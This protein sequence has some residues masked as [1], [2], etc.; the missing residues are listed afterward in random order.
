MVLLKV[1]PKV[2]NNLTLRLPAL[3]PCI[4]FYGGKKY[5]YNLGKNRFSTCSRKYAS[6]ARELALGNLNMKWIFPFPTLPSED[7]LSELNQLSDAVG[8]FFDEKVDSK[9]MDEEGKF[10]P[11]VVQ[12]LKDLGLFGMQIPV[13][14]GGLGL[15][16]VQYARVA[17]ELSSDAAVTVMLAA[18]QAI[19]LKGILIAGSEEQKMEYL[20]KLA[21]G[22][23]AA[24]FCLTEPSSG[25]DAASIQSKAHLSDDGQ[26]WVLNGEK[27]WITNGGFADVMT[28]FAKTKVMDV[29]D[30]VKEKVTAFIVERKFGG[31]SSGKPEDKL[32]IRASNTCA[33]SFVDTHIPVKNVL[34]EVGGGF[35]IAMNILNSGRFSMGTT[36]AGQLKRLITLASEYANQRTQFGKKLAEFELI[37]EKIFNMAMQAY[38]MESMAYMTAGQMDIMDS[39]GE[40]QDC[41]IEAAMVKIYSSECAWSSVSECLQIFGG[42]GYMKDFPYER[43]LRDSRILLIFEGTNEILRLYVALASLQYAGAKLQQRL[44]AF[45]AG[46]MREKLTA[47]SDQFKEEWYLKTGSDRGQVPEPSFSVRNYSKTK[48]WLDPS[49]IPMGEMLEE[50][51]LLYRRRV[52]Q[53]LR[54]YGKKIQDQQLVLKIL[55]DSAIQ[56]YGMTAVLS[57]CN[58]S[59]ILGL[60][61]ADHER[62]LAV[63]FVKKTYR[64]N[65]LI[66]SQLAQVNYD[67]YYIMQRK[68][69]NDLMEERRYLCPHPLE[70]THKNEEHPK[71]LEQ[72]E[73]IKAIKD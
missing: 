68:V 19:G 17:E 14:Y 58:K 16:N 50:S 38:A 59:L 22:E 35:K 41:S 43:M 73:R 9:K 31:V 60:R 3:N 24:A 2:L 51:T 40:P 48:S 30:E 28:V 25:S 39:N 71:Y 45:K 56:I 10:D 57:R 33:V 62:A 32:G 67:D 70:V 61:N 65:Y 21:T 49:L 36:V 37:Q 54:K 46:S 29:N 47:I 53:M 6:F 42:L 4:S 23:W 15:N 64:D 34:G 1:I 13:E 7:D 69:S 27:I 5:N 66:M 72:L 20:P 18:H 26:H 8:R 11:E 63:A 44:K 52:Y 55:A 12:G